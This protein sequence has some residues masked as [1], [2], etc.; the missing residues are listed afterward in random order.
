MILYIDTY[1]SEVALS[2]NRVLESLLKAVQEGAYAYRKQAKIDIL[3]YSIASYVPI[4][5]TQVI[6]RLD[7][8]L[9]GEIRNLGS[10]IKECF[11]GAKVEFTRSDTGTKYADVL[12]NLLE[13]NPWIFFSPNN[14][15]PFLYHDPEIMVSL[16]RSAES[17]E[18]KFGLPVSIL[19]SHFTES[20]NSIDDSRY[21]YGYTGNF[22][23]IIDEDEFSY[24]VKS[25]FIPLLSLQIYRVRQ[26]YEMM[27]VAGDNRVI[28]TECLGQYVNI[29]AESIQIVPKVEC[30]RHYDAYMHTSFVVSNYLSAAMV[31][32]LFIPDNFFNKK[33]KIKYG[34]DEYF[35][36]YVNI[37]P[38]KK[39][40]RFNSTAGTDL[41][42]PINEVPAF[43]SDRIETIETNPRMEKLVIIENML[44]MDIQ[45]PW[46]GVPRWR[47]WS[48]ILYR[49]FHF[50]VLMPIAGK[51][52][53][54]FRKLLSAL[55]MQFCKAWI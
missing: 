5:W 38:L 23:K 48:I 7:G 54:R 32:P 29:Q 3:K 42:I 39:S 22:C 37:N 28:R 31:P 20:I 33:L 47:I 8:D 21:L 25:D 17:A 11:P 43:W 18:K 50:L 46:R 27:R 26:L 51:S 9:K 36:G 2:P 55:K 10:Y 12:V 13:G 4:K 41:A 15:H 34:F 19:Y 44:S 40:Y 14:D 45:N 53:K 1:I 24:T 35:D 16:Q 6:I 49:K 30:C 52:Y